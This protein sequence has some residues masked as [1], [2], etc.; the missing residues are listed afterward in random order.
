MAQSRRRPPQQERSRITERKILDAARRALA[1]GG[2]EGMAV[3]RVAATAGVSV[4]AV[5]D[6]FTDKDGLVHAVQHDLLDEVDQDLRA[7]F[8]ELSQHTDTP[9]A[10]LI[11]EAAHALVG[12]VVRHGTVMGPLIL[13]AAA[14]T[15]LRKRGDATSA[16]A[17]ELFTTL[18]LHRAGE[19]TCPHPETAVPMAF[20]AVFSAVM[21]QVIFG[22][23]A[24]A[25]YPIPEDVQLQ[26]LI[27]LCQS[28]LLPA[29]DHAEADEG[30]R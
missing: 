26:E 8:A 15:S 25:H 18:I 22:P 28:Y 3:A 2:W 4:G 5:Y 23:G 9:P 17:E 19:L 16:L 30:K 21:W 27:T 14:D 11:A 12:Q 7:A 24:G 29:V 6:R 20:R 13:R 10:R 1:E